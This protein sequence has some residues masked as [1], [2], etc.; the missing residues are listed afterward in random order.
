[1]IVTFV[2]DVLGEANNGTTIAT[3]NVA[4][5]LKSQGHEVRI[6]CPDK[7]KE[8]TPGYFVVPSIN[9]GPFN[10]YV[11]HN[12]VTLASSKDKETVIKALEGADVVHFNFCGALS[13]WCVKYCNEH[14]IP[15][16]ASFHAQAE[17]FT[18]HV[19]LDKAG[20]ANKVMYKILNRNL[21]SKVKAI[22]Y[23]SEFIHHFF[24]NETKNK[25][26]AYVI[27]NGIHADFEKL[28]VKRPPELEGKIVILYSA[29]YSAEKSHKVLIKAM[30]Y[31]K[32]NKDIVLVLAGA[33]PK[34]KKIRK[35]CKKYCANPA[36][37][38]FHSHEQMI[39]L[40]SMTDIYAHCGRVD[41]EPLGCLEA[42]SIGLCPVL[43]DSK[44]SAVSGYALDPN[45][46]FHHKSSKD[47]AAKIDYWIDHPQE[48]IENGQ[49]YL[50]Y[51]QKY[52]FDESMRKM[53][54]MFKE[55]ASG[56]AKDM[57]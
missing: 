27:S 35:L 5:Y 54:Q 20:F 39:E 26:P 32:H 14:N 46:V 24:Q 47:C 23:P 17:N 10:G 34:E 51:R 28:D 30:K 15:C 7:D 8:G 42:L 40:L 45:N 55:V 53:E 16:T 1:M 3:L 48:R 6:V 19:Y 2:C 44:V 57:I 52:N 38:G 12:G 56:Q 11:R 13:S 18:N 25:V 37:L 36:V 4:H 33:G 43:T 31:S 50:I 29:R 9:F 21:F 41:I 22:H 49:K